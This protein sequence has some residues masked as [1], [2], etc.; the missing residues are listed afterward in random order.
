VIFPKHP[1]KTIE[2]VFKEIRLQFSDFALG[3]HEYY[4]FGPYQSSSNPNDADRRRNKARWESNEP[5]SALMSFNLDTASPNAFFRNAT[6]WFYEVH[7]D[8]QVTC[9]SPTDFV[10]S[11][12]ETDENGKH[13]VAGNRG[14]GM[15]DNQDGTWMFYSKAADRK[16][17]FKFNFKWVDVFAKGHAFWLQFYPRLQTY[18]SSQRM[19]GSKFIPDNHGPVPY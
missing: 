12:V 3:D 14:F 1:S 16:S 8:V 7:G 9:A 6:F 10:F 19:S 15:K 2:A 13:P 18:L 17:D 11:T 5:G 4:G